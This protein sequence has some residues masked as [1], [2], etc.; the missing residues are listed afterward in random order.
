MTTLTPPTAPRSLASPPFVGGSP[1]QRTLRSV[2]SVC[3]LVSLTGLGACSSDAGAKPAKTPAVTVGTS[4]PSVSPS[5]SSSPTSTT[6]PPQ[7]NQAVKVTITDKVLGHQVTT[8][9]VARNIPWPAGNPVATES[10]E[11]VGVWVTVKAGD[12]YSADVQPSMFSLKVGTSA[13]VKATSEFGTRFG[14]A[15]PVIKRSETKSGWLFF[16]LDRGAGADLQ[17]IFNRPAYQVKTTNTAI[18]AESMSK[19]LR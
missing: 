10:F 19:A 9:T 12:R 1:R 3:A 11:I 7:A 17:L 13:Q 8:R 18:K 2:A 16:K 15:L 4:A 14:P 5:T 6:P